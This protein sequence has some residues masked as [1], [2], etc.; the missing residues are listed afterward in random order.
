MSILVQGIGG[1][2]RG[3]VDTAGQGLDRYDKTQSRQRVTIL[4]SSAGRRVGLMNLFRESG[5]KLGLDLR[6]LASDMDPELSSAC[7]LADQSFKISPCD[8]PDY[9]ESLVGICERNQVDL[10][11]P[12]IDTELQVLA[13]GRREECFGVTRISISDPEAILLVRDKLECCAAL[14]RLGI[15]V[16]RTAPASEA[17]ATAKSWDWPLFAKRISGSRSLGARLVRNPESLR[18][19]M[20]E[21]P[22]LIVQ[23]VCT[24]SEYTVNLYIDLQGVL[25]SIAAHRRLEVRDGEVSKAVTVRDS[26][27]DNLAKALVKAVP[28]FRG[29]VCFQ[30]FM[31]DAKDHVPRITDINARFGGGYPLAHAAGA[32]FTTF[33][34]AE[35][36][37]LDFDW[38]SVVFRD[39]VVM[40]RYDAAVILPPQPGRG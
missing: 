18:T 39:G 25:R 13:K 22:D 38:G 19:F 10:V 17:L 27:L 1:Q 7:R 3:A 29:P 21:Y 37:G 16:P 2:G 23:E 33:L 5:E 11:I 8:S 24:G 30:V 26:R 36:A 28:G 40:L 12:T 6:V 20:T 32:E 15:P 9:V 31:E 35:Q 34:L 4:V 14:G